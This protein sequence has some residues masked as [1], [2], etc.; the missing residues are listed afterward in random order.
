MKVRI[1]EIQDHGSMAVE[2]EIPASSLPL[3]TP[4]RPAL[5]GPVRV[6]LTADAD[7]KEVHAWGTA[8]GRV[9]MACARCLARFETDLE[10]AVD[11][12]V[13]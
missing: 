2:G 7:K 6:A 13:P 10:G 1:H 4:D 3:E 12:S 5:V 11:M 8:R 9:S